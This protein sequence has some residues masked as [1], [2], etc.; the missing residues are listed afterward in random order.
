MP[1]RCM[2]H[3][4]RF[5]R[6]RP[7]RVAPLE[8]LQG[9]VLCVLSGAFLVWFSIFGKNVEVLG[10]SRCLGKHIHFLIPNVPTI[11]ATRHEQEGL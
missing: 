3:V 7:Q 11:K 1:P 4:C 2:K 9:Y 6:H 5:A 10:A 8:W